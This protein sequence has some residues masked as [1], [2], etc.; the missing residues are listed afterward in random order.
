M[1]YKKSLRWSQTLH[2]T[3]PGNL[4]EKAD[5]PL[6]NTVIET[7]PGSDAIYDKT[8]PLLEIYT[9]IYGSLAENMHLKKDTNVKAAWGLFL[10]S[11]TNEVMVW[12]YVVNRG[13][14]AGFANFPPLAAHPF[15][16]FHGDR[17]RYFV[18]TWRFSFRQN[19]V[20]CPSDNY[21]WVFLAS[22]SSREDGKGSPQEGKV[23]SSG[24]RTHGVL[25][26]TNSLDATRKALTP[27]GPVWRPLVS[28][29]CVLQCPVTL[30]LNSFGA[31]R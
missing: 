9:Y 8:H 22:A 6:G 7:F 15:G 21:I 25:L 24:T 4:Y 28:H 31:H 5:F 11:Y 12:N 27:R 1:K 20:M 18:A 3:A 10:N 19:L 14:W 23:E 17:P 30:L 13:E 2:A 16:G 29:V 26:S